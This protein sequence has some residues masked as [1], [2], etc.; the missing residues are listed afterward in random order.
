MEWKY[1]QPYGVKGRNGSI[2]IVYST[3]TTA[4]LLF[5]VGER[6]E[7]ERVQC[8]IG[9]KNRRSLLSDACPR[10][11]WIMLHRLYL[12]SEI[13]V[14]HDSENH[15]IWRF[16]WARNAYMKRY[17]HQEVQLKYI[18][19]YMTSSLPLKSR[20][21]A[22]GKQHS[23]YIACYCTCSFIEFFTP[24][25]FYITVIIIKRFKIII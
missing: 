1:F 20:N 10:R 22:W 2:L 16:T 17:A 15:F 5:Y 14:V 21:C 3:I 7:L 4:H 6:N 8:D 25:Y 19:K 23:V 24:F 13:T 11:T 18:E 9:T 12:K